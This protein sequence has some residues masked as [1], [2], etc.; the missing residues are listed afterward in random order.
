MISHELKHDDGRKSF[1]LVL[2]NWAPTSSEM[3]LLTLHAS[4]FLEFQN[5][6]R[7]CSCDHRSYTDSDIN[8]VLWVY[9]WVLLCGMDLVLYGDA[10]CC[11][12]FAGAAVHR[13]M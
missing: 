11:G 5:T 4:A 6:V 13:R 9:G 7:P 12:R 1:P 10:G 2:I 3:G 8:S